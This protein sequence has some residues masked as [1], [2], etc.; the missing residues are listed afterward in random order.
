MGE[1][2]VDAD[3]KQQNHDV[4]KGDTT[5]KPAAA[6]ALQL[7][8]SNNQL[9]LGKR[10]PVVTCQPVQPLVATPTIPT[11]TKPGAATTFQPIL[12]ETTR[13]AILI[14]QKAST[15]RTRMAT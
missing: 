13:A 7:V 3:G 1:V 10:R 5:N 15:R 12:T 6:T 8:Q 9:T 11:K 2:G 14:R 4:E